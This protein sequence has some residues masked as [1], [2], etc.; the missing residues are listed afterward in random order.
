MYRPTLLELGNG[1]IADLRSEANRARIV[2]E[3]R[4]ARAARSGAPGATGRGLIAFW[5]R[6]RTQTWRAGRRQSESFQIDPDGR[7]DVAKPLGP[8]L[9]D[10]RGV[11]H[12]STTAALAGAISPGGED[13]PPRVQVLLNRG[14]YAYLSGGGGI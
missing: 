8:L 10:D 1:R 12:E 14:K 4:A 11:L 5:R 3:A 13:A 6:L 7:L 2:R 9:G